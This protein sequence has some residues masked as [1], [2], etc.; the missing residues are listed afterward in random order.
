MAMDDMIRAIG[1]PAQS[2]VGP[3]SENSWPPPGAGRNETTYAKVRPADFT[4]HTSVSTESLFS[5]GLMSLI[6]TSADRF[7]FASVRAIA[8]SISVFSFGLAL[9]GPLGR[10]ISSSWMVAP[11]DK[12]MEL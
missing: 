12:E 10:G 7:A 9:V 3:S 2:S 4:N 8:A 5:K 11:P 6:L 1:V